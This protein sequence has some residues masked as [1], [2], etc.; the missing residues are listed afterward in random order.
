VP[1][2]LGGVL[3]VLG[4]W[5]RSNI[6]ETPAFRQ[7][8]AEL[9]A[10]ATPA[11]H[12][13]DHEAWVLMGKAFG[14]T[15]VWTV[16]YYVMLSYIVTFL[17]LHA[18]L[19]QPQALWVNAAALVVLVVTT[20][21]FGWLSD[22]IGRKPLLLACCAAFVILPYPVFSLMLT[23]P[24]AA[25]LVAVLMLVN[26]FIAAFSGAGPAALSE[27][28]PTHRRTLLMSVGYSVSVAIFG[29]F[30]PYISTWLIKVTASPV[31]PSFYLIAA[32]LVSGLVIMR[33]RETAHGKLA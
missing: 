17:Q 26:L 25:V 7:A 6:E 10:A 28:F 16:A 18:G 27:I 11:R 29:G 1:F 24:S 33:F 19:T 22:R 8:Q 9:R 21:L 14:F 32:G 31:S 2:L 13:P 12:G 23:K 3:F 30:A 4:V 15:I 5:M 20:P